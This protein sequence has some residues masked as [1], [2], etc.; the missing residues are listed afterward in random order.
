MGKHNFGQQLFTAF[1][2]HERGLARSLHVCC[3]SM[4]LEVKPFEKF[5]I[6]MKAPYLRREITF[7]SV[8]STELVFLSACLFRLVHLL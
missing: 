8:G 2:K 7:R 3:T 4:I 5:W 6:F 1:K